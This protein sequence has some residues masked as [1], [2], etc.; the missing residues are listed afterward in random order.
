MS[1]I[2][3][4]Q[5]EVVI[6]ADDSLIKKGLVTVRRLEVSIIGEIVNRGLHA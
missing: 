5:P 6:F 4:S 1:K 3:A 2:S